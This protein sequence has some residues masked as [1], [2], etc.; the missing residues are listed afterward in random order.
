MKSDRPA[1]MSEAD[2]ALGRPVIGA[3]GVRMAFRIH[4]RRAVRAGTLLLAPDSVTVTW[5]SPAL[6]KA[7]AVTEKGATFRSP[8]SPISKPWLG[9]RLFPL[10]GVASGPGPETFRIFVSKSS[11]SSKIADQLRMRC[12]LRF[13]GLKVALR[14]TLFRGPALN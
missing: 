2:G 12:W 7:K 11:T 1:E 4:S 6:G 3:F 9:S 5:A 14:G 10:I 13:C 8:A